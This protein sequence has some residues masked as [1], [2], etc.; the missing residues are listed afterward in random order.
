MVR[1]SLADALAV[2]PGRPATLDAPAHCL[3]RGDED[4]LRQVMANLLANVRT[5]TPHDTPVTVR[6]TREDGVALVQVADAGPS[7]PAQVARRAFDR[8]ARGDG[9]PTGGS[10][11]G[12]AILARIIAEHRGQ[13][14]LDSGPGA[15]TTVS[16]S[17]PAIDS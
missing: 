14:H 15:G 1:D 10:G 7:M 3:V 12:L 17:L 16:F 9:S 2:E 6:L 11:L 4:T 5:H 13:V 8:F